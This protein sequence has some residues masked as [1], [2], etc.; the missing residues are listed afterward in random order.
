MVLAPR[1]GDPRLVVQ[2]L[3][4]VCSASYGIS[5]KNIPITPGSESC[6]P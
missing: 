6:A 2:D 4:T 3:E 5:V 1:S